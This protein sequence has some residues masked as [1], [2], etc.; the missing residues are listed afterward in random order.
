MFLFC[1]S[2]LGLWLTFLS[3]SEP[4]APELLVSLQQVYV[5][6]SV[7]PA[8]GQNVCLCND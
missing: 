7:P 4:V 8:A 5:L 6:Q 3:R 1:F 2:L